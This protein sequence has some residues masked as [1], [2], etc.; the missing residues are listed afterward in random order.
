MKKYLAALF[1]SL[2]LSF[3]ASA[4]PVFL[5]PNC[6]NGPAV[7]ECSLVNNTGDVVTCNI[8]ARGQTRRGAMMTAFEYA[9]LYQG[10]YAWVRMY[11]TN[12]NVDPLVYV[13]ANAFCNT[14]N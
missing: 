1:L 6:Y 9:T 3:S 11:A 8:E 14:V 7:G 5:F 4:R 12:P 2:V 13:T 10:M